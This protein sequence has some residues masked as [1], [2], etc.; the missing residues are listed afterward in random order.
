M[1]WAEPARYDVEDIWGY[2]EKE[3]NVEIVDHFLDKVEYAVDLISEFPGISPLINPKLGIRK[4]VLSEHN[5]L[6]YRESAQRIELLRIFDTR[7]D[8]EVMRFWGKSIQIPLANAWCEKTIGFYTALLT[9]CIPSFL[10]I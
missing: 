3:W 6:F 4:C 7:Q 9:I 10:Y 5:S 2:L 1:V 8:P